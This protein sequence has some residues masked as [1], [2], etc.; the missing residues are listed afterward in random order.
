MA[1]CLET[2]SAL[3]I[4]FELVTPP[5]PVLP[6]QFVSHHLRTLC[7]SVRPELHSVH[8]LAGATETDYFGRQ[9]D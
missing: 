8:R 7:C 9:A 4:L 2:G 3:Q 6:L 1:L 5:S